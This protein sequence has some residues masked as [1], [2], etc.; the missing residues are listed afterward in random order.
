LQLASTNIFN[1]ARTLP[2]EIVMWRYYP[3][4][5]PPGQGPQQKWSKL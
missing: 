1:I 2:T 4:R 5:V 3:T